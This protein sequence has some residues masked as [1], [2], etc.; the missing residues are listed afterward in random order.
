MVK[1]L[2]YDSTTDKTASKAM[3]SNNYAKVWDYLLWRSQNKESYWLYRTGI[4]DI[5]S[6][7]FL[8]MALLGFGFLAAVSF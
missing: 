5:G 7:M 4:W 1:G 6:M 3:R 8:G 2:K